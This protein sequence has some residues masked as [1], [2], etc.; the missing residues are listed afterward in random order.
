MTSAE[1]AAYLGVHPEW[2]R[3]QARLGL[4]PG[5][6]KTSPTSRGHWKFPRTGCDAFKQNNEVRRDL[7]ATA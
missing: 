7:A 2:L 5:A 3:E 1:A 6:W 4:V